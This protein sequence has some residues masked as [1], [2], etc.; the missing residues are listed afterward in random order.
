M[1]YFPRVVSGPIERSQ[2]FI[3]KL[4]NKR[5]INSKQIVESTVL[6]I[7]GLVRKIIIANLLFLIMPYNAFSEPKKF[8][9]LELAVWLLAFSFALYN[10]FAGYSS[11]VRGVSLFF[12]IP[13]VDNFKVPYLASNF[14][15]FWQ[16][17]HIS[18]SSWLREY[19]FM[20]ITR[21]FRKRKS[22]LYTLFSIILP[23]II[24][25]FVSAL[26]HNASW[27]M[28]IWGGMYGIYLVYERVKTQREPQKPNDMRAPRRRYLSIILVYI[29]VSLA[30]VPFHTNLHATL[31]YWSGLLS[32]YSWYNAFANFETTRHQTHIIRYGLDVLILVGFS[33]VLD[34]S[35][36]QF[37]ELVILGYPTPVKAL[38][39][40][41][42]LLGLV[43]ALMAS[44][45]PPPFIYQGY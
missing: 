17:W 34:V 5:T 21:Y 30:W 26:W 35:H 29:L 22:T 4:Q 39:L 11:I 1:A 38:I 8:N 16:R 13:L 10:D 28:L 36:D 19:V 7:Q 31:D 45:V 37:G 33:M 41:F 3:I 20:P 9:S 23:P 18:L 27:N 12:G 40:N 2:N 32:P 43:I 25:M 6:V 15:E 24:T 14:T 42:A 44:N